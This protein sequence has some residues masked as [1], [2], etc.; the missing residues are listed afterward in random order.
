MFNKTKRRLVILNALVFFILQNAFGAIIYFYTQYSLYQQVDHTILEKK[1]HLLREKEKMGTQLNPEREENRRLVYLLWEKRNKLYQVIP[2]NSISRIDTGRFFPFI[3]KAGLQTITIGPESYR[4][5]NISVAKDKNYSPVQNIQI[6]YNL[7]H[8]KEML[9]R[10]LM[11]IGFGSLLSVFIA[12][13]A[14]FY[15]AKKALIPI[16]VSWEKQQQF[17]ADASHELRTPLSVMK[18]NLEHLFRHPDHSI[19]EESETIHQSIQEI[20]YLSKMTSDL[21]TLA[22]S[23]SNQL[24]IIQETIQLDEILN[25]VVKDFKALANSRNIHLTAEIAPIVIIGDKERLKQLFVILLDNA[26]KYTMENGSISINSSVK[27]AHANIDISDT[28]IGIPKTDLPY[29]FD[30]YYRGDKSRNRHLEGSGLGL[31]IA[32]WIIQSHSG[33]I[34]VMSKV[35]EGTHVFVSLPLKFKN[36][37]R[38]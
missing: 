30:R 28:G 32:K 6:I 22:R 3:H 15:L 20:N 31:S 36:G 2:K 13:L 19:E 4:F 27:N 33:K 12:I 1:T 34:R 9:S 25:Q 5:I 26:I 23:D 21:L 14:G 38:S 24:Q 11:V 35:G 37:Y 10:L 8:E 7:K 16:K 18:L 29:I 17:V